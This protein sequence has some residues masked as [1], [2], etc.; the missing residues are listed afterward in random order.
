M[1]ILD[2]GCF[3][4]LQLCTYKKEHEPATRAASTSSSS[5]SHS[6]EID[7]AELRKIKKVQVS[8]LGPATSGVA[9]VG[10]LQGGPMTSLKVTG[11]RW[12][13]EALNQSLRRDMGK[14]YV[15]Q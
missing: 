15:Q 5:P 4:R 13:R 14:V 1:K 7:P 6:P 10:P 12:M 9:C 8:Y 2:L 3:F 11:T